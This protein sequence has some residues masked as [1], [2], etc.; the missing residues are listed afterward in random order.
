MCL[1]IYEFDPV[2]F[3]IAPGL[4]RQGP[5]KK[6]KVKLNLLTHS[7]MLLMVENKPKVEYAMIFIDV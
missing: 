5:L 3:L 7:D 4:V 1:A 6:T 2:S